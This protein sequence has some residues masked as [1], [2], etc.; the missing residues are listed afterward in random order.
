MADLRRA[1]AF[2][3]TFQNWTTDRKGQDAL[4]ISFLLCDAGAGFRPIIERVRAALPTDR[5][6]CFYTGAAANV[7]VLFENLVGG[8]KRGLAVAVALMPLLCLVLFRSVRLTLVSFLPNAFPMLVL[9]GL[10]GALGVPLNS[11]SAMVSTIALGIAVNETVLIVMNY[12][13]RRL[14]GTP[15]ARAMG[16]TFGSIGRP[17]LLAA[18]ANAVGFGIFIFS[19]FKPM[20]HFGLLAALTFAAALV[21]DFVLLPNLLALADRDRGN[22]SGGGEAANPWTERLATESP[23][24]ERCRP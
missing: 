5:F 19:D 8:L 12:Q 23:P 1:L 15:C 17:I 22:E 4:R 21:G 16:E 2:S 24:A 3:S 10:M 9:F 18:F 11:G 6:E 7:V 13:R 14:E 20:Y